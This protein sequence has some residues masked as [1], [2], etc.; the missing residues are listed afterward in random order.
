M[1]TKWSYPNLRS[2]VPV[3]Y[4]HNENPD[5][6]SCLPDRLTVSPALGCG[7]PADVSWAPLQP[8]RPFRG[9]L[10]LYEPEVSALLLGI[11]L[12]LSPG[13]NISRAGSFVSCLFVLF[14]TS[15][16]WGKAGIFLHGAPLRGLPT[17]FAVIWSL[18]DHLLKLVEQM[19]GNCLLWEW[20]SHLGHLDGKQAL[21][22][23]GFWRNCLMYHF[24]PKCFPG[25]F[26]HSCVWIWK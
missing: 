6:F 1:K 19:G 11:I 22:S 8:L 25:Y 12:C 2:S 15:E 3:H 5:I 4:L 7:L 10:L 26:R 20:I 18:K 16:D 23:A 14:S 13:G 9:D 21:S 24:Q 17:Q